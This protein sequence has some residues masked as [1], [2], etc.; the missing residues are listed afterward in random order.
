MGAELPIGYLSY[1]GGPISV[2]LSNPMPLNGYFF[3]KYRLY[4]FCLPEPGLYLSMPRDTIRIPTKNY[5][6]IA[7]NGVIVESC[8]DLLTR[9]I[10]W[11]VF[12][13]AGENHNILCPTKTANINEFMPHSL[14]FKPRKSCGNH[15][16]INTLP[17]LIGQFQGESAMPEYIQYPSVN[18]HAKLTRSGG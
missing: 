5:V 1:R 17:G 12:F 11:K 9:R 16:A 10:V 15:L 3:P 6:S 2:F 8:L 7:N 14:A 13:P 18:R 4:V